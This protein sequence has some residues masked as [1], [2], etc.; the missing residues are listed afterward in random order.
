MFIF[1][2]SVLAVGFTMLGNFWLV[3]ER[4]Y[5]T[6]QCF[7]LGGMFGVTTNLFVIKLNPDTL[8]I[9]PFTILG[10]WQVITSI[11]GL[12]KLDMKDDAR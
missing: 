2:L 10:I 12:F 7:A 6:Y 3:R 9:L 11:Y 8:G 4:Y 1:I 5:P